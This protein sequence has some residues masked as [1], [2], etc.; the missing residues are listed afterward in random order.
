MTKS[1]RSVKKDSHYELNE[2]NSSHYFHA[3][4]KKKIIEPIEVSK[5]KTFKTITE[6]HEVLKDPP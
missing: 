2:P 6:V 5:S 4:M 3:Q 1:P